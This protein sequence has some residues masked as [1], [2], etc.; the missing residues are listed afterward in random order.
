[1]ECALPRFLSTPGVYVLTA[2][3][4]GRIRGVDGDQLG[5]ALDEMGKRSGRAQGLKRPI[6][7][8][9]GFRNTNHRIVLSIGAP[10][11]DR[12]HPTLRGLLR[13]GERQLCGG[14]LFE[15]H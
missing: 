15:P 13:V 10:L 7:S 6:T 8:W 12:G 1:M 14:L 5:S 2:S 4:A 11:I 9:S 3:E